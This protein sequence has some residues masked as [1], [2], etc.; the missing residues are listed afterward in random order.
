[1][2]TGYVLNKFPK[3]S[4]TFVL[5]EI[6]ELERQGED[7][8][9]FALSQ[10]D[11]GHYQH[12]VCELQGTVHYLGITKPASFGEHL[13]NH[14][15]FLKSVETTVV[16]LIWKLLDTGDRDL[17]KRARW[18]LELSILADALGV[19]R[20]HSH[21]AGTAA[22]IACLA[23]GVLNIPFSMTCHAKDLYHES[24]D[25]S[26]FRSLV[27]KADHVVTVC[28]ANHSY[29]EEHLLGH[30]S[31]KLHTVYNGVDIEYFQPQE[32][33]PNEPP[34]L[35]GVGRLVEK[36]GFDILIDAVW[37][38][39]R[40]GRKFECVI[41]GEGR[42]RQALEDR[43]THSGVQSVKLVGA[44]QSTSVRDLLLRASLLVLPCIVDSAGNRD[45]LPTVIIEAMASGTPVVSTP[46]GGVAEMVEDGKTG[47]LVPQRDSHA[48]SVAIAELLD[49][50]VRRQRYGRAAR[51]R[52]VECFNL[53]RNV[54]QLR[55]LLR[56]TEPA[57]AVV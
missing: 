7:V 19:Q 49:D 24:V 21:F 51:T 41:V 36:K 10:P 57:L 26:A 35:L 46:V 6:R 28:N 33:V 29:I 37:A 55:E 13:K 50:D 40:Q 32:H 9:V 34:L 38:L 16:D 17:F 53:Q 43:I 14:K 56:T 23:S 4:E 20:L 5:N 48:L 18:A 30:R 52:A 42:E 1:M 45:A 11:D 47:T 15:G 2:K 39:E 8:V 12:Q 54:S 31:D 44:Q 3:L 22:E 25:P 27:D